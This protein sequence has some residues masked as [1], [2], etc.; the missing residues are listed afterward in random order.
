[1]SDPTTLNIAIA[2]AL[3]LDPARIRKGGVCITLDGA[4]GPVIDVE[5]R[6]TAREV[7]GLAIE[8]A[9]YRLV[10]IEEDS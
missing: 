4:L 9:R 7:G 10:P 6:L 8:L 2:E 5:Y 1:V 3:G